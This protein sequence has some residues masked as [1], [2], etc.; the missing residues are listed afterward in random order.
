MPT[1]LPILLAGAAL[2]QDPT[3]DKTNGAVIE[4]QKPEHDLSAELGFVF[5]AGNA[6]NIT[7]NAAAAYAHR[8]KQNQLRVFGG[9]VLNL[10]RADADGDG[11]VADEQVDTDG[12]GELDAVA[13]AVFTSQR[14]FGGGR[15]DRFFGDKNAL[16]ISAMGEHDRYAG[17]YYRFNQQIGYRR[18]LAKTE[19]TTADVEFGLAYNEENLVEGVDADGNPTNVSDLDAHYLAFRAFVG[20]THSFNDVVSISNGLEVFE[21]LL[22]FR[23]ESAGGDPSQLTNFEDFRFVNV[24]G[25]N[26]KVSDKFAFK[27]S[28]RLAFDN[29]PTSEEYSKVDNTVGITLVASIL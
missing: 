5:T 3:Y 23:H 29:Q 15:Y 27:I 10:A 19:K 2:A 20:V 13:P 24:F 21:P 12:D 28:D 11:T 6:Y 8:W 25:L 22:A 16:Y 1:L 7:V 17:V 18:V 4:A 9:A 14:A 26:L